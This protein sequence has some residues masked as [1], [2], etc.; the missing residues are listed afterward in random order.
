MTPYIVFERTHQRPWKN[1]HAPQKRVLQHNPP[2][3]TGAANTNEIRSIISSYVRSSRCQ[4]RGFTALP[5]PPTFRSLRLRF[6]FAMSAPPPPESD[7]L[8]HCREVTL[9][10]NSDIWLCSKNDGLFDRLV[11]AREHGGGKL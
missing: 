8:L 10:A 2:K 1:L 9:R 6:H 3:A 5:S 7:G 11:S 4:R